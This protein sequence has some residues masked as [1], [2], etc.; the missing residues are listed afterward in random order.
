MLYGLVLPGILPISLQQT[1]Q[2][3]QQCKSHNR[4]VTQTILF[5]LELQRNML[6]NHPARLIMIGLRESTN[7][8]R[9]RNSVKLLDMKSSNVESLALRLKNG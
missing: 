6:V 4:S 3:S 8:S 2:D 7:R 1:V 5:K 9:G